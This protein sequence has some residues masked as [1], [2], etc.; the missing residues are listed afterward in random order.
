MQLE[1]GLGG[2]RLNFQMNLHDEERLGFT[3]LPSHN[4]IYVRHIFLLYV[5]IYLEN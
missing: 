4:Y 2:M 5:Q 1:G 3:A